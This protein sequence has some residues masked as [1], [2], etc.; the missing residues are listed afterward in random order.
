MSFTRR[1]FLTALAAMP[2]AQAAEWSQFRGGSSGAIADNSQLPETWSASEN[3]AWK[4]P[5]PGKGW[6]S[7]VVWDDQ[8]FLNTNISTAGDEAPP[9][10]FYSGGESLP[11]PTDEHRWTVYSID[12]NSGKIRWATDVHRGVPKTPR[13]RKNTYA[14]ETPATDGERVY[15][16]FGD[17][18]TYCLD[19]NGKVLWSKPWPP[20]ETHYGYGTASSSV[21]H[22][23]RLYI[24]NDNN[25][26]SYLLALDKLSGKEIWR[27]D[28]DE[29]TT[30]STPFVWENEQRT[31]IVTAGRN[32]VRSYDLDGKLLW[33][34]SGM[35]ALSLPTPFAVDGLLYVTSGF[36]TTAERPVY[37]I[38]PG[39]S[40][41]ITPAAGTSSNQ[42]LAW[43][44]PQGGPYHPT[45]VL[46]DGR[47]YVLFDRG[48][49][50][51]H[52]ARS[53]K[54]I[55]DKRRIDTAGDNFTASPW[56]YNGKLFCLDESGDT[57]V[58]QA[59][60]DFKVLGKN[61]LNEMCMATPAIARDSLI[62]RTYAHLYRIAKSTA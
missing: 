57:Y 4:T 46:Y 54:E 5:I 10:G 52:E 33:E 62:I 27:V 18:G 11:I 38:R 23:G 7:P 48:F 37:A 49:L 2:T 3:I 42:Y 13:H 9:G 50:T 1:Y 19:M 40:G 59:G 25:E 12:F 32:K 31:E 6:S 29:P 20:V 61:S 56:A 36:H 51:C 14:S 21:V 26:Q 17:L 22:E 15:A 24:L 28:R 45:P 60:P 41:D 8:I 30:W 58:I 53:G 39:A 55:Y 47:F 44:L 16:H 34:I 35:S 43:S